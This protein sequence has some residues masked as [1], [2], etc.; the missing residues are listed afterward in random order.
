MGNWVYDIETYPNIFTAAFEHSEYPIR[1]A[2]EISKTRDDRL[3]IRE[4]VLD[5]KKS[6]GALIG[7]N[8]IGFDYPVL[9]LILTSPVAVLPITIYNKA[10]AII[11]SFSDEEDG[12]K[13]AHYI[14]PSDYVVPQID[15]YRINHFN[16]KARAT[17]LKVLEFNMR[18]TNIQDLP[19]PVGENVTDDKV[20]ILKAYNA[21]DVV[22]TKL[23]YHECLEAIELRDTLSKKYDS[24]FTN[25]DDVKIGSKIFEIALEKKG[26]QLYEFKNKRKVPRQTPRYETHMRECLFPYIKFESPEFRR[27]LRWFESS[28]LKCVKGEIKDLAAEVGGMQY[29][30]GSGGI[31][32]A[33]KRAVVKASDELIIESWDVSSY[34]PSISIANSLFPEH[35]GISFC[36]TY[37]EIY[38]ER[39]K[40]KKGTTENSA[41]KLALNGT[42]GKTNDKYSPFLDQRTLL[43]IT[44]NGQLL[45][46]MLAE[47]LLKVSTVEVIMCNTDGLEYTVHKD[48]VDEARNKCIEWQEMT[49]LTLE[50]VRYS[51]MFI[52]DSNSYI[53]EYSNGTVKRK[54]AYQYKLEW[55]KDHSALVVPKVAELVLLQGVDIL[56]TLMNWDVKLDFM[57]RTKVPRSSKLFHGDKQIQN[58]SRYY[59]AEG[60]EPLY[61]LMPPL[62]DKTEW[63][64]IGQHV[65]YGVCVCNDLNDY[66][67]LPVDYTYYEEEVKKLVDIF[68]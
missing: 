55:H 41:L 37:R 7:F 32:A 61:K 29:V 52:R 46:C 60:G 54:G 53:A 33:K 48:Y 38:N 26:V 19:I 66:E 57:L 23:F 40:T 36:D 1:V 11:S 8:N 62:K 59:I 24:D 13:F 18:M 39:K 2:F 22:T 31:H 35:I 20:P 14:F 5:V 56:E 44:I 68:K 50:N 64:K 67:A 9:H 17:S 4:F 42:Y 27:V 30:F 16:N 21:H 3:A 10:Q 12:A 15:L 6:G 34:Y 63:R 58:V 25:F 43:S 51:R 28:I 49:K 45:L 65:G 47:Q